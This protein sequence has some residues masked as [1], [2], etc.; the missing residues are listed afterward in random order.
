ML[1]G[2]PLTDGDGAFYFNYKHL[3]KAGYRMPWYGILLLILACICL[4]IC[5]CIC[6]VTAIAFYS[7]NKANKLE[8]KRLKKLREEHKKR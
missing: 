4:C 6:C 7:V 5:F 1:I 2:V 3:G 8:N